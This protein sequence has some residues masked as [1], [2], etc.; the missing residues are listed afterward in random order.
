M[1]VT[2]NGFAVMRGRV[3]VPRLGAWVARISCSADEAV[4]SPVALDLGDVTL[5]G[6][7]VRGELYVGRWDGL[8]VGGAGGLQSTVGPMAYRGVPR[9]VPWADLLSSS[10]EMLSSTS[11]AAALAEV[12]EAW[13]YMAG[14]AG[15]ALSQLAGSYSWRVL[16]D[17]TIWLGEDAWTA[18]DIEHE[19][20]STD[21]AN[22]SVVIATEAPPVTLLPGVT[23]LDRRVV[24]VEHLIDP[25]QIRTGVQFEL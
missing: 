6:A 24:G 21:Y 12:L 14:P 13:S 8:I 20:V 23:F 16:L 2:C 22:G 3:T 15:T 18:V 11:S 4:E 5:E 9:S 1:T 17:G 7:V 25:K 10:G 19:L